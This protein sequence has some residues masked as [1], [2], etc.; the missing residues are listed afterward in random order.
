MVNIS[1]DE[2]IYEIVMMIPR[3]QVATYG[4]LAFLSG[5]PKRSRMVGQ[6]MATAPTKRKLPCHR[7]VNFAGRTAPG[8]EEQR[9]LLE[10]EGVVF[11]AN[12]CVDLDC[13]MWEGFIP[14]DGEENGNG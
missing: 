5:Y 9:R 14:S 3:G 8:W 12:G 13:C 4:Q 1:F 2:L 10:K 6:T 7:V 11:K